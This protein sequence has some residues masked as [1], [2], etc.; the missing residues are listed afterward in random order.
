MSNKP[1]PT[2]NA[3]KLYSNALISIQLGIEDFEISTLLPNKGGNPARALSSVRNLFAGMLLLFKYKIAASV[4]TPE[5]AYSLIYVPLDIHP[6]SNGAGGIE[7]TLQGNHKNKTIDIQGIKHR[8]K[9]FG[10]D[11]DWEKITKLQ[12]CRNNLEHL[13]PTNTLG[14]VAGFVADLFPVLS[15]FITNQLEESP[16]D[17]LSS[18]WDTMLNH[19]DFYERMRM[20][21]E[22]SWKTAGIPRKLVNYL[23]FCRCD[24]CKSELIAASKES[25][26]DGLTVEADENKFTY[27]CMSCDYKD[28]VA[29][30]LIE[31]LHNDN[32]YDPSNGDEAT[33]EQCNECE[34]D[35]FSIHEQQCAWCEATLAYTQCGFCTEA[36]NQ[37]DQDNNGLCGY[38]HH[39]ST[40]ND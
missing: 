2:L 4:D 40:K 19:H 21:C 26:D 17:L 28:V 5:D 22:E 14:E 11:V 20:Q 7:W 12:N 16:I 24:M 29:P 27:R 38:H 3:E 15:D 39:I 36:L 30:L 25:V 13:H 10:I 37:D 34:H 35:T 9:G 32:L 1:A 6:K 23:Q 18:S 8:L 31:A 33:V